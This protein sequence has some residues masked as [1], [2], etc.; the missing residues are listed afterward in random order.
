MVT[1]RRSSPSPDCR[2]CGWAM[3]PCWVASSGASAQSMR[4]SPATMHRPGSFDGSRWAR[5]AGAAIDP[6]APVDATQ[7]T[8]DNTRYDGT[9]RDDQADQAADALDDGPQRW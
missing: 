9:E 3:G 8:K 4:R 7:R 1:D 5:R 2:S 6:T